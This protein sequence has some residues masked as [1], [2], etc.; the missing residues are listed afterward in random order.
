MKTLRLLWAVLLPA[1]LLLSCDHRLDDPNPL[2]AFRLKSVNYNARTV[3]NNTYP[4]TTYTLTYDAT[5][6]FSG[7]TTVNDT[8]R[9][10]RYDSDRVLQ[11][12][13]VVNDQVPDFKP[14][15]YGRYEY[16][17]A[18]RL[19]T[20]RVGFDSFSPYGLFI[21]LLGVE[22]TY[23]GSSLLPVSRLDG[24]TTVP[25]ETYV[26]NGENAVAINGTTYAYDDK[27]NP[28]R[29]LVGFNLQALYYGNSLVSSANPFNTAPFDNSAYF[30]DTQVKLFNRNNITNNTKQITYNADG[31][32]MR[33]EYTNG[34]VEEFTYERKP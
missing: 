10:V 24:S 2:G 9:A 18:G 32:V 21:R 15:V 25:D 27:P 14:F 31:L 34:N 8:Y 4:A 28:Y 19:T 13:K 12:S 5:G 6:R 3:G 20:N 1:S 26:F 11:F 29:G 30:S 33:I 17:A 16:D 7:F 23:S 22:F